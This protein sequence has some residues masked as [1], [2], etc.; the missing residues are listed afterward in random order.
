MDYVIGAAPAPGVFILAASDDALHQQFM[1]YFKMGDGPLYCFTRPYHLCHLE[2]AGSI[3]RAALFGDATIAP[4][5]ALQVEVVATAKRDL[6]PGDKL[7]GIGQFMLYGQC[8]NADVVKRDGLLPMGLA[9]GA[10]VQCEIA[11]DAVL[12][13][14]DVG[15]PP[16][17][18]VDKLRKEQDALFGS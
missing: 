13:M 7:D 14:G 2:I 5:G 6:H 16:E 3:A 10:L 11:Q 15:M 18:L 4:Q 8:E 12:R 9:E 1:R 17:R